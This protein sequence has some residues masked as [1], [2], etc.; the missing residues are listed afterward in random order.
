LISR[1][2][3]DSAFS[4]VDVGAT[5]EARRYIG[6]APQ[7]VDEFVQE[8]IEPVR[9]KYAADLRWATEGLRV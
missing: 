9:K 2:K 6:R 5:L 4:K 1:L 8:F 3:E 7:Q